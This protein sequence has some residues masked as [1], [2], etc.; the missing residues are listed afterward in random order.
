MSPRK[1]IVIMV[2]SAVL[3]ACIAALL[4]NIAERKAEGRLLEKYPARVVQ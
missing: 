1:A 4:L 3:T 2:V